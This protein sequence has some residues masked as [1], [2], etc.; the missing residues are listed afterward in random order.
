M[1]CDLKRDRMRMRISRQRKE[2][3]FEGFSFIDKDGTENI[4]EIKSQRQYI[5]GKKKILDI[6]LQAANQ[7]KGF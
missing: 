6:G 3:G 4:A 5:G 2:F 1:V 7:M